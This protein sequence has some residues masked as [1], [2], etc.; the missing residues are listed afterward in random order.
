MKRLIA[1]LLCCTLLV[2]LVP[3][4]VRAEDTVPAPVAAQIRPDAVI[5]E[6]RDGYEYSKDGTIWLRSN[7][8]GALV[9][10]TQYTFYQRLAGKADTVSEPLIIKTSPKTACSVKPVAPILDVCLDGTITLVEREGYEY[11]INGGEWKSMPYFEYL[12]LDTEYVVEQRICET[13]TQ[14]AS[15]PSEPLVVKTRFLGASSKINR[16]ILE[17]YLE[18]NGVEYDDGTKGIGYVFQDELGSDYYLWVCNNLSDIE[19]E[20]YYDGVVQ[21]GLAMDMKFQLEPFTGRMEVTNDVMLV[22]G[23]YIIDEVSTST[24]LQR[25]DY[26]ADYRYWTGKSGNYLT[27][28]MLRDLGTAGLMT[29]VSFWD[30]VFYELFGFGMRGLG[31]VSYEGKGEVCCDPDGHFHLD[32]T[33]S[34]Y[35]RPA[36]CGVYGRDE[37]KFCRACGVVVHR[38]SWIN[39]VSTHTYDDNCDSECNN[40]GFPRAVTH[41]FDYACAEQCAYCDYKREMPLADHYYDGQGQCTI[42]GEQGRFPGDIT[43]DGKVN[44][45]D[46]SNLYAHVRGTKTITDPIALAV[47]DLTGDGK[48]NV[49]DVSNLYARVRNTA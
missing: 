8:F 40:C 1:C 9:P 15:E 33:E 22:D 35:Y 34:A 7:S 30:E 37:Y 49:A 21:T 13:A 24:S 18:E 42:C 4:S 36:G 31:F 43:G 27:S 11:R 28:E 14:L 19:F 12:E 44:V 20:L 2:S 10:D 39:P 26:D 38:G 48:L 45:A 47:A 23:E 6:L 16:R 46:V 3:L 5:L 32:S 17:D 25:S 41:R 29:I